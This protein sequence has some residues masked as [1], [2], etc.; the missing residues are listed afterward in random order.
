M[1]AL[2]D[3]MLYKNATGNFICQGFTYDYSTGSSYFKAQLVDQFVDNDTNCNIPHVTSWTLN[4]G[5]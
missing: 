2:C 5:V 1:S 3:G 4:T